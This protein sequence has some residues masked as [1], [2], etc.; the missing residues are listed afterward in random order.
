MRNLTP[1]S[2]MDN[3]LVGGA[4]WLVDLPEYAPTERIGIDAVALGR[5]A[6]WGGFEHLDIATYEGGVDQLSIL[7]DG[8]SQDGTSTVSTASSVTAAPSVRIGICNP[9]DKHP[10]QPLYNHGSIDINTSTIADHL[11]RQSGGQLRDP[12]A[13][14]LQLD[15]TLRRSLRFATRRNLLGPMPAAAT[16]LMYGVLPR[17][18]D[19]ESVEDTFRAIL[20]IGGASAVV[21]SGSAMLDKI[22]GELVRYSAFAG[23]QLD[24]L[25][26]VHGQTAVRKLIKPI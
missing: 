2:K 14:A 12:K 19:V 24:R 15:D 21:V 1:L 13:W 23:I 5:L 4:H 20:L 18:M 26:V 16:G 17:L 6:R 3:V 10:L 8:P 22:P 11:S 25:A 7:T 9:G